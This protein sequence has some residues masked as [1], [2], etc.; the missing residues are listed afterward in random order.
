MFSNF[1]NNAQKFETAYPENK[2]AVH[3]S[4]RGYHTNNKYEDVPAFMNDGR[5][6]ISTNQC[7][8][9]ENKKLIEDN[10]IKSNWEY[11]RYLTKNA[12]DIMESNYLCST[13]N[14]FIN[15]ATDIPSIQSNIVNYKVTAPRKQQNVLET[16]T[17]VNSETTDLKVN[18][19]TREQLEARKISPAITQ[20]E[21]IKK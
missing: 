19:L 8:S 11:R 16:V 21:L 13:D 18:Y 10:N 1:V 12:K 14:G 6:L 5:S 15:K 2:N 3:E 4:K 7:D 9:I 20:E 17:A